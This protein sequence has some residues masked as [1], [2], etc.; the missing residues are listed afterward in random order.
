MAAESCTSARSPRASPS[1]AAT[2]SRTCWTRRASA[3]V[4]SSSVIARSNGSAQ[5]AYR[6]AR[7]LTD[8]ATMRASYQ[9]L[10]SPDPTDQTRRETAR[11][12]STTLANAMPLIPVHSAT[13]P[14]A[15][16]RKSP[17]V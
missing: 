7:L 6:Q 12:N 8:S 11:M 5:T 16:P 9:D 1:F 4:A 13:P 3:S 14:V 10:W 2:S 17:Q 15:A